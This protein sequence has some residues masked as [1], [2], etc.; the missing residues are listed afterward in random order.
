MKNTSLPISHISKEIEPATIHLNDFEIF[1]N[2]NFTYLKH[3]CHK[4]DAS[5]S[6]LFQLCN[7]ETN[8]KGKVWLM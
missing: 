1:M 7:N 4:S 3:E 8:E 6:F 2:T 5:G